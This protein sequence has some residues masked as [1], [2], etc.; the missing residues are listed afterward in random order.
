[1]VQGLNVS[2]TNNSAKKEFFD[3]QYLICNEGL[4]REF[5]RIINGV[6]ITVFVD[7]L[8]RVNVCVSNLYSNKRKR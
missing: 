6:I 3:L 5:G 1:M 2:L 4:R 7:P 8:A